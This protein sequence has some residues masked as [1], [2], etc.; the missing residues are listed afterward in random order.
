MSDLSTLTEDLAAQ[1]RDARTQAH[2][3]QTELA[4]RLQVS[5]RT[6]QNWEA[7]IGLPQPKHR[8]RIALFLNG[9]GEAA[10]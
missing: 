3:S 2:L 4:A 5:L 8:R 7:G 10:A 6:V 1:I 9:G